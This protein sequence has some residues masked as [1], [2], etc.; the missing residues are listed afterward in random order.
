MSEDTVSVT[1]EQ[2]SGYEFRIR[3]E[4][5]AIPELTTDLSAPLGQDAGPNPER[6]L[7]AAVIN[8]LAASLLFA[9]S[10]FRN[11]PGGS[12]RASATSRTGR[13]AD[14]RVRVENID[15]RLELPGA[16]A[17]Y[18]ALDR[19]LAQFESFCTVTESVR[20]GVEVDVTVVDGSG[21]VLHSASAGGPGA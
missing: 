21:A 14:K 6:L 15:V 1:L 16:A 17:D 19:V 18:A 2:I 20:A 12:L 3:F 8:C 7:T 11:L 9:L 13:N 10:K 5:S 4:E